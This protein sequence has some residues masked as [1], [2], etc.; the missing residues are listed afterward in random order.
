MTEQ[1]ELV[2]TE[3]EFFIRDKENLD[4]YLYE[5]ESSYLRKEA[6]NNFD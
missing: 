3:T 2:D 4:D 1:K 5:I 6:A